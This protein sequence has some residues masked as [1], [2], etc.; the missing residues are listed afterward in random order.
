MSDVIT[1][2]SALEAIQA[3][4]ADQ[5]KIPTLPV[6]VFLQEAVDLYEWCLPDKPKLIA[7][8]LAEPVIDS[9]PLRTDICRD[10][11]AKWNKQQK[12]KRDAMNSWKE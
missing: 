10:A 11:Q 7:A 6:N 8:N 3:L 1:Q 5:I 4:T 12:L 9:L 2:T